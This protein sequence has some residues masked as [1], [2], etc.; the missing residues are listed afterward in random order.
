[1]AEALDLTPAMAV[2]AERA[3]VIDHLAE[4]KAEVQALI[5]KRVTAA[6][7]TMLIRRLDAIADG[8]AAGLHL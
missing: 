7:G 1:M 2:A 3:A 5:G 4:K 6:E 8:I